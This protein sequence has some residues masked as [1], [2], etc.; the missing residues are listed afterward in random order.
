MVNNVETFCA[1]SQI[2]D[3]GTD[4]YL[5]LGIPGSPGTKLI[6]VS[7]DC[8]LPGLYEIE[9][10]MTV[11][12]LLELCEAENPYYIQV[13]GP[14][15]ECISI[16]EKFR[17]ISMLDLLARKD[18][19]CGGSFMVFN[20]DR[21]LVKVL[22]NFAAFFKQESCGICTPCRAGNFIIQ[23]KLERLDNGLAIEEDL[24]ELKTWGE[25]MK[26]TSRCGLGKTATNSLILAMD[27]FRDYFG[28]KLDK[29]YNGQSMKFDMEAATREYETY[30]K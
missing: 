24:K 14:S 23:R 29:S 15:G 13:S 17:R 27:K 7:G 4:A 6:S 18:I 26:T 8:K 22:L 3:I 5:K 16:K 12:E 1:V 19:R 25:I 21:D 28:E 2:L 20:K 10:G 30:K 11:A 9:W